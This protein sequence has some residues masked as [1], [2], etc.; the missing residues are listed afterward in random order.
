LRQRYGDEAAVEAERLA[1]LARTERE[2]GGAPHHSRKL[3]RHLRDIALQ[4]P[5]HDEGG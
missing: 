3:Y 4:G 2:E 1:E 5:R